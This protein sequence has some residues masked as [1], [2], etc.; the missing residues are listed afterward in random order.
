MQIDASLYHEIPANPHGVAA[1]ALL[2][3]T[4]TPIVA[5]G[6]T[7]LEFVVDQGGC[8]S[9]LIFLLGMR[10]VHLPLPPGGTEIL[11]GIFLNPDGP[12]F[13]PT[14]AFEQLMRETASGGWRVIPTDE[15]LEEI[16]AAFTEAERAGQRIV[17][18]CAAGMGRTGLVSSAW[19][20]R[21][22]GL[23]VDDAIAEV[24]ES[25]L[26]VGANRD[27]LEAGPGAREV[28]LRALEHS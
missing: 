5:G 7:S 26:R 2:L 18:H 15:V 24:C 12:G 3:P 6:G 4:E 13:H 8:D 14:W 17:A 11:E 25:A 21:R 23:A 10:V 1:G 9:T 28:L 22:Y 16:L 19:L 20:C 27:P